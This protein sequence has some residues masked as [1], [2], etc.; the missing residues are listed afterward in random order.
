MRLQPLDSV[1][2]KERYTGLLGFC[3]IN[4]LRGNNSG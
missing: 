3:E 4:G 2:I 1:K